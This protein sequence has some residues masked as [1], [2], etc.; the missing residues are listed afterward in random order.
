MDPMRRGSQNDQE[1][2]PEAGAN[3]KTFKYEENQEREVITEMVHLE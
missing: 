1:W 2:S 3:A